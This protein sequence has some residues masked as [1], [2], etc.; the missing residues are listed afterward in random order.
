MALTGSSELG[1]LTPEILENVPSQAF[2]SS[3][4]KQD[5]G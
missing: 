5:H 1:Q 4:V 2:A 3:T